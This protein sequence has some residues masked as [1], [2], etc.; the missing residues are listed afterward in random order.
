ML[1]YSKMQKCRKYSKLIRLSHINPRHEWNTT[2]T[3]RLLNLPHCCPQYKL[4]LETKV[5]TKVLIRGLLSDCE[6]FANLRL[7][8]YTKCNTR[9][10]DSRPAHPPAARAVLG[11]QSQGHQDTDAASSDLIIIAG[12]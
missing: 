3:C 9:P 7:K 4:E 8:L 5:H 2:G 10:G 11:Q 1:F 12:V 6:I